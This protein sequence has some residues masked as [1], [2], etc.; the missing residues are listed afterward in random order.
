MFWIAFLGM[1]FSWML[2][3]LGFLSATASF[4][5][6]V[7]KLLLLVLFVG[8]IAGVWFWLRSKKSRSSS[9]N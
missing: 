1:A 6:F 3:K 8:M 2:I 7:I 5:S 4:L 9:Q